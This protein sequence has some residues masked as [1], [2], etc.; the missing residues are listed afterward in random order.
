MKSKH[1]A[2][3]KAW[4]ITWSYPKTNF[5][6]SYFFRA[7]VLRTIYGMKVDAR[8]QTWDTYDYWTSIPYFRKT[9]K[10]LEK[11]LTYLATKFFIQQGLEIVEDLPFDRF[12]DLF[13]I[14]P[15]VVYDFQDLRGA[16]PQGNFDQALQQLIDTGLY[17]DGKIILPSQDVENR[18]MSYIDRWFSNRLRMLLESLEFATIEGFYSMIDDFEKQPKTKVY[19]G[20]KSYEAEKQNLKLLDIVKG[21][22]QHISIIYPVK[23]YESTRDETIGRVVSW[24]TEKINT[25][26]VVEYNPT[27]MT[28][29]QIMESAGKVE[30]RDQLYIVADKIGQQGGPKLEYKAIIPLF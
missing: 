1:T 12:E 2:T 23:K 28:T 27:E 21:P 29:A 4:A 10:R 19:Y 15:D 18:L 30:P 22:Y 7:T 25:P 3:D 8:I 14:N 24:R 20:I 5:V 26:R 16:Y 9:A 13:E 6:I 17:R 11:L